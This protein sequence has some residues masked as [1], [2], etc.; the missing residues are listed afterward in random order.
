MGT[1]G[2]YGIRKG[3]V[4]KITYNHFDSY[5]ACLG[6]DVLA[7]VKGKTIDELSAMF[8]GVTLVDESTRPTEETFLEYV[9]QGS[10]DLGVS[11]QSADDWYCVLRDFQGNLSVWGNEQRHVI[12]SASFLADSLFCEWAYIVNL[13]DQTLEVYKGFNKNPHA[14][15]RY[16]HLKDG[17]CNGVALVATFPLSALPASIDESDYTDDEE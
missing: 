1:R 14:P 13:D 2:A 3:G 15:G 11:N 17:N 10:V 9:E 12:D 5:P 6:N 8:D 16:A 7:V 4:D